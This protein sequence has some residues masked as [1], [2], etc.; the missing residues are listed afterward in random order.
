[1]SE[2]IDIKE[3]K[4]NTDIVEVIGRFLPLRKDGV[5]YVGICPFHD[6]KTES[7]KVTPSK[8]IYKCFGCG[9]K[10]DV[11]DFLVAKGRTFQEA[12]KELSDPNN[13]AAVVPGERR[14]SFKKSKEIVWKQIIP[15][16]RVDG[17]YHHYKYGMPAM[18]FDYLDGEGQL[19][20]CVCRFNLPGGKKEVLPLIY[21][22][23]GTR[24]YWRFQGFEKPRPLYGLY[25]LI[26]NATRNVIIVEG[27]KTADAVKKFFPLTNVVTW[28]GGADGVKSADW[29]VLSKRTIVFWPDNDGP[30]FNAMH[31]IYDI[32]QDY[33]DGAKWIVNP[34]WAEKH[35]DA[36][37]AEWT[38]KEAK[39][40]VS[41]NT[42]E[43]PGRTFSYKDNSIVEEIVAISLPAGVPP[44]MEV[45][46]NASVP[47]PDSS[48]TA[49]PPAQ[50]PVEDDDPRGFRV[51]GREHFRLLG[52]EKE[53]K[54]MVYHFY[55]YSTRTVIGLA[56]TSMSKNNLMQ[57]APLNW[58]RNTFPDKKAAFS[59]DSAANYLINISRT[60]GT[61]S[62]R[63][64]RG[65]GAW[66]DNKKIIIHNG[67]NLLIDGKETAL[68]EYEGKY[69][70]EIGE[71]LGL[72][73][74]NAIDNNTSNKVLDIL[75]LLNWEN[76][77]SAFL[78]AGWIVIAPVC[79]ALSWRPHVWLTGAAGTGKSWVLEKI[80]RPLLGDTALAVQGIASEAGIR[81][82]LNL[83]ALPVVFDEAE[84]ANQFS[85]MRVQG[86]LELA[87]G[88]STN[89]G[90]GIPKGTPGGNSK[91][92][93]NRSCFMFAS[94][95]V[96]ATE[97]SDRTRITTLALMKTVDADRDQRWADFQKKYNELFTEDFCER[98]RARTIT[99]LPT[100]LANIRT[101]R[102]AV[103]S[104][105]G[106]RR[107]GDQ[108]G[109]MIAGAY[110]LTTDK[111]ISY[112]DAVAWVFDKNWDEERAISS[113]RDEVKLLNHILEQ[114][115]RVEG[116]VGYVERTVGE[117]IQVAFSLSSDGWS[118]TTSKSN[119]KLKRI[120][121]KVEND[122]LLISNSDVNLLKILEK[123]AWAKN[124]NK[125]LMRLEGA[126][127][128]SSERFASGIITR[129]VAIPKDIMF[130][131]ME[132]VVS[133]PEAAAEQ[134]KVPVVNNYTID[135]EVDLPF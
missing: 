75:K 114:Q 23:D 135:P 62:E 14:A 29:S 90:G 71:E 60:V 21:A 107:M 59:V 40:Y 45:V 16:T 116:E 118:L 91:T 66:L 106:D 32:I 113:T 99:L 126:V 52:A 84:G 3:I 80:V 131:G 41:A 130:K 124:H 82:K 134:V 33:I 98:F 96:Q 125:I 55:S 49:A 37:D 20:G 54:N 53:G 11:I 85:Q 104:V 6:E 57:L 112:D 48:T 26:K 110:S 101:F 31:N 83:D 76:P 35:W 39:E 12:I 22:T 18:T 34:A 42:I 15:A 103:N 1:M 61:F 36:A 30:G 58:W 129:A 92:Y 70:Y 72:S 121:L 68:T 122:F 111:A 78:L 67:N 56:P 120:G 132:K 47:I 123:T 7:F 2:K 28:I 38:E 100:I 94:I 88:A 127:A 25:E 102:D 117:L 86:V 79:G 5:H 8:N 44:K 24:K 69:I 77:V 119:D 13:T 115:V 17:M 64:L 27:E 108:I 63:R 128:K 10:G 133:T 97:H 50:P 105:I 51:M 87:R 109:T 73:A 93:Q 9:A 65:R 89:D 43:Y 4:R 74:R 81:Q 95:A 46:H 19:I